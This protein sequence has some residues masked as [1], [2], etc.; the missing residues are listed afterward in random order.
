MEFHL[1]S[2][3]LANENEKKYNSERI[4]IKNLTTRLI[5]VKAL[6]KALLIEVN[7]V[8]F[9]YIIVGAGSA[10]CV[11][12]SRLTEQSNIKVLLVEAG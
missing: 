1:T 8:S 6:K 7:K 3:L 5:N 4:K 12:A 9:D 2:F 10:G 11:L